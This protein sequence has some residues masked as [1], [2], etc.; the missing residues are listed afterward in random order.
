MA[1][2]QPG[3]IP[4]R[5]LALDDFFSGTFRTLR[6]NWRPMLAVSALVTA[7]VALLSLPAVINAHE[8]VRALLDTAALN[9]ETSQAE[10]DAAINDVVDAGIDF[11]PWLLYSAVLGFASIVFVDAGISFVTSR[12]VLGKST[13]AGAAVSAMARRAVH[14]TGLALLM[15]MSILAGYLL[16]VL[17]GFILSLVLFAAPSISVLEDATISGSYKR[18]FQIAGQS[19]W[20]VIGILLLVQLLFGIAMQVVSSPFSF[21]VGL[22]PLGA[23]S[24][25]EVGDFPIALLLASYLVVWLFSLLCYPLVSVGKTLLYIDQRMRHEGL[26]D[27]LI[28]SSRSS[29]S[30]G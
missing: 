7:I 16:C 11:L 19:F 2:P 21:I 27:A 12:A 9:S 6:G 26:A 14:L 25:S 23:A 29:S 17:P 18:S 13:S 22:G 8:V 1:A 3:V 30:A 28:A 5:P 4:L 15:S 20:R 10:L 24:S